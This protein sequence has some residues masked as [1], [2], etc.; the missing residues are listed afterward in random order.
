MKGSLPGSR[1]CD[2]HYT[3]P[4][5]KE[6]PQQEVIRCCVQQCIYERSSSSWYC[7]V[8]KCS[9]CVELADGDGVCRRHRV[10]A[11]AVPGCD[12]PREIGKNNEQGEFCSGHRRCSEY[13]NGCDSII[14]TGQVYCELHICGVTNCHMKRYKSGKPNN[15]YCQLRKSFPLGPTFERLC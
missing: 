12:H 8:H 11:C 9:H 2:S 15:V 14:L 5:H 1:H 7:S 3:R 4:V 13:K 6:R 10:S